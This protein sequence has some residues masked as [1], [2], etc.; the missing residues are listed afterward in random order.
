M[1]SFGAKVDNMPGFM[2]TFRVQGQIYHRIGSV[3]PMPNQEPR[4]LQIFFTG[5]KDMQVDSRCQLIQNVKRSIVAVFQELFDNHNSLI[6]SFRSNLD[7]MQT[8]NCNLIICADRVPPGEHRGRFNAPLEEEAAAILVNSDYCRRDIV[9]QLRD[10]RLQRI[11]E[12]HPSYDALQYP[13][14]FWKGNRTYSS[15]LMQIDPRTGIQT[16]KKIST[17][18]Y[19]RH[20]LMIR[21]SIDNFVLRC[22][23]L[24]N[25]FVVDMWAKIESERLLFLR[26]NQSKLRVD[27]YIHLRDA[28]VNDRNLAEIGQQVIL[29]S[30]F[31]GGPRHLAEYT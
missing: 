21:T 2:P 30:T 13:I 26:L 7:R 22:A 25:Q 14:I 24:L 16:S 4:F 31:T 1:T 28:I 6:L 3:L 23:G 17:M 5:D 12:L 27:S 19:Y 8:D 18:D 15:N 11:D 29:P 20:Q 9:I 10:Q